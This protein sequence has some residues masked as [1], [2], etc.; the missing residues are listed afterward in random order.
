MGEG[1]EDFGQRMVMV[2][3]T[4]YAVEHRT[5]VILRTELPIL[6]M[7]MLQFLYFF[8][9]FLK[10]ELTTYTYE[11]CSVMYRNL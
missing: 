6:T 7:Q 10:Q 5:L 3:A 9:Y 4:A 8:Y 2:L 11:S 1:L